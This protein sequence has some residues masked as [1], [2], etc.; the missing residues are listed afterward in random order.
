MTD[1]TPQ[2]GSAAPTARRNPIARRA[3]LRRELAAR[4]AVSVAELSD[5]Q[6]DAIQLA[7]F[8]GRTYKQ[9]ADELGIPEGTAKSRLRLGLKHIADSL[10][11]HGI[12]LYA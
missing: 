8:G 6:R 2:D 10:Q 3:V 1:E 5:V 9:V 12:E 4:G 11:A 7:Y